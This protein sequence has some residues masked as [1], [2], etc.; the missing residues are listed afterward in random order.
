M[1][2]VKLR[3]GKIALPTLFFHTS[4]IVLNALIWLPHVASMI[5]LEKQSECMV[6]AEI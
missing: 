2:Y 5:F 4:M 6:L 1:G 3:V